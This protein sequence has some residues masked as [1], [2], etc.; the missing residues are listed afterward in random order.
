MK[1]IERAP[2]TERDGVGTRASRN[3]RNILVGGGGGEAAFS[4]GWRDC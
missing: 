1:E 2:H 3:T 4:R